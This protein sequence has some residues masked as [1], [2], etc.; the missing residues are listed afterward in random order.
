M[1]YQDPTA[2]TP[3]MPSSYP[4][5]YADA[6]NWH[7][8]LL[9]TNINWLYQLGPNLTDGQATV[10]LIANALVTQA[11]L[12]VNGGGMPSSSMDYVNDIAT[13]F[14]NPPSTTN[15]QPLINALG[16]I[17]A[18]V[19]ADAGVSNT[20]MRAISSIAYQ[21]GLFWKVVKDG[22]TG[23]PLSIWHIFVVICADIAGAVTTAGSAQQLGGGTGVQIGAGIAGGVAASVAADG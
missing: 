14:H 15:A 17:D 4:G 7:N 12:L 21:S 11:Q 13:V 2:F 1:L 23:Q 16:A 6:G 20:F 18:E 9:Y 3:T 8:W 22:N 19:A 5:S 10:D